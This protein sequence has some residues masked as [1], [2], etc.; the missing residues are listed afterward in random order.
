MRVSMVT[1]ISPIVVIAST[2]GVA[3][4]VPNPLH[5]QKERARNWKLF[6]DQ[7]LVGSSLFRSPCFRTKS[8]TELSA[9]SER[10]R[11]LDC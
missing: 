9:L 11:S 4:P 1:S 10:K 7:F 3:L 8:A 6:A 5:N 2:A